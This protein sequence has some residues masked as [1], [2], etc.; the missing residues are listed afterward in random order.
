MTN[1][2]RLDDGRV[3]HEMVD[4]FAPPKFFA[5]VRGM[6]HDQLFT[7]FNVGAAFQMSLSAEA[8]LLKV[9]EGEIENLKAQLSLKEAEVVE[10]IRLRAEASNFEVVEKSFQDEM[11]ALKERNAILEKERNALDVKVTD[12]EA[13]AVRK[14]RELTDLNSLITSV[15]SHNDTIVHELEISSSGLQEKVT[16]YENCMEHLEKF[17][18]DRMKVVGDKFDKLYTDFVEM[19]LHLEEKFYPHLLTTISAA[20][21]KAIEKGMQDGL[22]VGITH[23]KEGRV[24]TDVAAHNPFAEVDYISALQQL[25]NVNLPLL[26]ELKSNKDASIEAV[27]DILRLENPLAEKLGLNE[28]QPNVDQL[29]VPIHHSPNKVVI[30]ATAL[31]LALDVSSIRVQKIKENIANQRSALRDVFFPLAEPFSAVVL[32]SMEGTSDIVSTTADTTTALSTTFASARSISPI[33]ID[34]YEVISS[35]DQAVA[36]GNVASFPNVDDAELNII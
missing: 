9:R 26:A 17:Q 4:E 10:S 12:L 34:D 35:D 19:A 2:S 20:I 27:M 31:S 8:E 11:N 25:Q 21:G 29:M 1:G 23:G 32:I 30:G 14:E 6:E 13:S 15:K 36:D 18:D 28:L 24:L 16:V 3:C 5:S 7:E 33:S 22:S